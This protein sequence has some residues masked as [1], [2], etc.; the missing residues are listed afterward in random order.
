[1]AE[2]RD[3]VSLKFFWQEVQTDPVQR[4]ELLDAVTR[5]AKQFAPARIVHPDMHADNIIVSREGGNF[6]CYLVD[7][8]GVSFVPRGRSMYLWDSLGWLTHLSPALASCE[9]CRILESALAPLREPA[10][11]LWARLLRLKTREDRKRWPARRRR[12]LRPGNVCVR[13]R[14]ETGLWRLMRGFPMKDAQALVS[15][16]HENAAHGRLIQNNG[17]Q[18]ISRVQLSDGSF[19]VKE[20][21]SPGKK[22]WKRSD[23]RSWFCYYRMLA[24]KLP[25]AGCYA[26]LEGKESG[27]LITEDVGPVNLKTY[28]KDAGP[29]LRVRMLEHAGKF[30]AGLHLRGIW[31]PRTGAAAFQVNSG[32]PDLPVI[33]SECDDVCFDVDLSAEMQAQ[34][35]AALLESLPPM[36]EETERRCVLAAYREEGGLKGEAFHRILQKIPAAHAGPD[37]AVH[38]H[39]DPDLSL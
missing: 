22:K 39:A 16:H 26:W 30:L 12:L 15:G 34:N 24:T 27:Y 25:V 31:H 38:L 2:V 10:M 11:D 21:C 7:V 14:D 9:A 5:L 1:M 17:V 35:L 13:C 19:I 36:V 23:R 32:K 18:R 28:L 3:A 20:F 33:L 37:L 8:E 4:Q 6:V 29:S